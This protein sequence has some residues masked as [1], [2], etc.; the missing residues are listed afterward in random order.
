MEIGKPLCDKVCDI[1]R[2][3]GIFM[4]NERVN[5]SLDKVESKGL[6]DYVSY[7]DK[8]SEKLI[9]ERLQGIL[10]GAGF[11]TEEETVEQHTGNLTWIIDPLDGTTNYIHGLSPYAV[12]IALVSAGKPVLGIVYVIESD[13]C[14]YAWEGGGTW[15]NGKQVKVSEVKR[16]SDSLIIT[17]FPYKHFENMDNY[18]RRL[19]F[20]MTATHGVRRLGSAAADLAYVACGRAE[21]FYEYGLQAWDV[22]AGTLLVQEAGG[23]VSDYSGG[24]KYIFGKELIASNRFVYNEFKQAIKKYL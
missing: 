5:F 1:A 3:A 8:A 17:G 22:A 24:N 4:K 16:L 20:F 19:E 18:M 21:A 7:V 12:S 15:L 13:E 9:V 2:E 14:F 10:P 23:A 6:H 11:L